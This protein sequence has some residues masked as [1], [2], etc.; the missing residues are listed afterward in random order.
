MANHNIEEIVEIYQKMGIGTQ[1]ERNKFLQWSNNSRNN[2]YEQ[3]FII[4]SP[5][6]DLINDGSLP[7]EKNAKL[8]R[9]S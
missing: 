7:E 8:A 1:E 5:N 3:I 6:S 4:N 2:E 9:D